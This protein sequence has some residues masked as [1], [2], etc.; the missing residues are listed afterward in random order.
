MLNLTMFESSLFS[1]TFFPEDTIVFNTFPRS[2]STAVV[3]DNVVY[4]FG[5]NNDDLEYFDDLLSFDLT[6]SIP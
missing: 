6:T 4:M 1:A 5:G 2:G 3:L